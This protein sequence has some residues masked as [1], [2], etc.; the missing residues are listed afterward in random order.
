[1]LVLVATAVPLFD[2]VRPDAESGA[3]YLRALDDRLARIVKAHGAG[4]VAVDF[5]PIT[6]HA[7]R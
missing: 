2:G 4:A 7:G 3:A 5:L 1:M 6:T